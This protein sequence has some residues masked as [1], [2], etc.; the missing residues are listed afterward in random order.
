MGNPAPG[1]LFSVNRLLISWETL[2]L[3][4]HK[5][6]LGAFSSTVKPLHPFPLSFSHPVYNLC[7]K[8]IFRLTLEGELHGCLGGGQPHQP[9]WML[10]N[11]RT[12]IPSDSTQ[13]N[14]L[15][16]PFSPA[17][18]PAWPQLLAKVFTDHG[19]LC[20]SQTWG[21]SPADVQ[22][23][24]LMVSQLPDVSAIPSLVHGISS[25]P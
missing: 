12:C 6:A 17:K 1:C 19:C 14:T 4:N 10:P 9:P 22:I 24:L 16:S 7:H 25:T 23:L 11:S 21:P 3:R 18:L 13:P 2:V 8:L 5:E 20:P 15:P